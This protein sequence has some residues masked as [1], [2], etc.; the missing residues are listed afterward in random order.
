MRQT[1]MSRPDD[2]SRYVG[3]SNTHFLFSKS[4]CTTHPCASA[5]AGS[6][7]W[8]APDSPLSLLHELLGPCIVCCRERWNSPGGA[9]SLQGAWAIEPS[10]HL[11]VPSEPLGAICQAARPRPGVAA[12][13]PIRGV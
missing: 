10:N 11:R 9:S 13:H 5:E 2:P 8:R 6:P 1:E 4:D 3:K 12:L 7:E